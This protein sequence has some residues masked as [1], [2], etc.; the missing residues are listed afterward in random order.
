ML[1]N[2]LSN[3]KDLN[4]LQAM[5]VAGT[6]DK[7]AFRKTYAKV[8]AKSFVQGAVVGLAFIGA[9]SILAVVAVAITDGVEEE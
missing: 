1:L 3:E 6:P 2:K 7:K 5:I 9:T 8:I 4:A